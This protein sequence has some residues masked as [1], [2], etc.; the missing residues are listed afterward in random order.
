MPGYTSTGTVLRGTGGLYLIK[1]DADGSGPLSGR[2]INCRARGS[3][4]RDG[5]LIGDRVTVSYS[6]VSAGAAGSEFF[7]P[8]DGLPDCAVSGVLDR[9]NVLIR[10]PMANLD[11]IFIVCAAARPDPDLFTV[12]K[13]LS[14][15]EYCGIKAV[16]IIGKSDLDP[17]CA[18]RVK[19]IYEHAGYEVFSVSCVLGDGVEDLKK[20]ITMELPGTVSAFAGVSGAGKSTLISSL[21][22]GLET[23][24]GNVSRKTGRGRNTTR[25][26][27]LYP[28]KAGD[29]EFLLADTPGFSLIDF[30]NFDF[31][32]FE[33]LPDTMRDFI[34]YYGKCRYPDC[35][36]TREREC[37][38][39][40]AV[41]SGLIAASRHSSYVA[42]YDILKNK[43][44]WNTK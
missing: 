40:E 37:A 29:G 4:K 10:P 44:S 27:D 24:S 28:V 21:F 41:G 14:V 35:S 25:R 19:S 20:Y 15:C 12:D 6:D 39:A 31:L 18:E 34:P 42:M 36:H 22:P 8:G 32:P 13:M 38:I 7:N 9:K 30:E 3:L 26:I 33:S 23:E 16:L 17:V 1:T 43:K 5:L 11:R 2:T